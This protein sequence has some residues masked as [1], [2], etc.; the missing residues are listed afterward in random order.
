MGDPLQRREKRQIRSNGPRRQ[1][2][3]RNTKQLPRGASK[4]KE[5]TTRDTIMNVA[6][7][8]GL[9]DEERKNASFELAKKIPQ[10][11]N[12]GDKKTG[13][14]PKKENAHQ[15]TVEGGAVARSSY[16]SPQ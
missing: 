4:I 10:G 14:T 8:G 15:R 6:S 9:R 1:E 5:G 11:K 16:F 12:I 7:N 3:K 2:G 13:E